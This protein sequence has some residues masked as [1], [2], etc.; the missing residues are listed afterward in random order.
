MCG[1]VGYKGNQ[2]S[3]PVLLNG[4]K[5]LEY[6]GY[7]SAGLAYINGG[8]IIIKKAI[9][10][11]KNLENLVT[12]DDFGNIGIAHTRWATHGG[13]TDKNAH[14]HKQG[15]ITL[16][17]NGII[18]NYKELSEKVNAKLLSETTNI[19]EDE[20]L[21]KMKDKTYLASLIKSYWFL[22]DAILDS[23]IYYGL[24]GYLAPDTYNFKDKDVTVEEV[25]KTLLDQEEK[26]LSPYKDTLSKMN[27]HEVLTLASISELEGLKDTDRKLIVGVFQNRLS[28]GMNLGSD[29][30]TYYAFNQ[31]MDKDLTSEM[32]NTYNPYNTRSSAMA[33][34]LPV[35]PICNPSIESIMASINPTKSDY[36]YFVA[37]KNGNVYYTKTS[38]EH[39]AKVKELKEKGD[40]IW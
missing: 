4:L 33:G 12:S 38:S 30:T 23:N 21:T 39:S 18:E 5:S 15:K 27:V 16:V 6:R 2:N 29:V 3:I 7:D 11:V 14:P 19:S 26:N 13:V 35:G 28:K 34:K 9:G 10:R 1:I 31:A 24:E 22:T 32:F 17:H 25:I 8:K 36:Y 40:W 37:D 20:F